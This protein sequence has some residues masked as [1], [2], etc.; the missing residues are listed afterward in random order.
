MEEDMEV[1]NKDFARLSKEDRLK[2]LNVTK[3]L[4][5][6]QNT[7]VPAMLQQNQPEK[8]EY[9]YEKPL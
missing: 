2:V 4:V 7:L 8:K 5:L 1:M 6:T 9:P 3:Y